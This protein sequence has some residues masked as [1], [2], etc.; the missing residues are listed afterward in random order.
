MKEILINNGF[1]RTGGCKCNGGAEF[2]GIDVSPLFRIDWYWKGHFIILKYKG[3]QIRKGLES[4]IEN[5]IQ[6]V[7]DKVHP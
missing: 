1:K 6:Q 5:I 7:K 4:E 3:R 2:Y